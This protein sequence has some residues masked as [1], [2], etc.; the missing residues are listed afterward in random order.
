MFGLKG[1]MVKDGRKVDI[2]MYDDLVR[3]LVA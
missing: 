1:L 2:E 3:I